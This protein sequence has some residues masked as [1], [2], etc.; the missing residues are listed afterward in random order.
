MKKWIEQLFYVPKY[1][2]VT[3][4]VFMRRMTMNISLI[5]LCMAAMAFTAYAYF[6][7]S[8]TSGNNTLQAAHFDVDLAITEQGGAPVTVVRNG[9]HSY[10]AEL[11]AGV[12]YDVTVKTADGSTA[13]TGFV[14]LTVDDQRYFTQQIARGEGLTFAV[15]PV[16]DMTVS[17]LPHWGTSSYYESGD[18]VENSQFYISQGEVVN[19]MSAQPEDAPDDVPQTTVPE[20]TA[21]ETTQPETTTPQT[22]E[23]ETTAPE[24]TVPE[25]TV[26]PTLDP[27][28][29]V[30]QPGDYLKRI[31]DMYGITWE[32]LQTYNNIEG[33]IIH[34]GQIL[35]IPPKDQEDPV[36]TTVPATTEPAATAEETKPV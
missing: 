12:T 13:V 15:K 21:P 32:E 3:E 23:P 1:G 6:S 20:S 10:Y 9:A 11:K 31:A 8:V 35:L 2:K 7:H 27:N 29:Y 36:Q 16:A 22:T 26:P 4:K 30:V 24:T 34:P 14:L 33:D 5:V 19:L 17:L 25:T 18:R 28:Q